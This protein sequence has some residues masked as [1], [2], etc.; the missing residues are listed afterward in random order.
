MVL[1]FRAQTGRIQLGRYSG[2]RETK[3]ILPIPSFF[4]KRVSE[5]GTVR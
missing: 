1:P 2:I 4:I 5:E 3:P